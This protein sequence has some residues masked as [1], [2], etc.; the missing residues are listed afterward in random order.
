MGQ[1][2]RRDHAPVRGRLSTRVQREGRLSSAGRSLASRLGTHLGRGT[3]PVGLGHAGARW[4][5]APADRPRRRRRLRHHRPRPSRGVAPGRSRERPRRASARH[6]SEPGRVD[7][8]QVAARSW[9][10]RDEALA[11]C[12]SGRARPIAAADWLAFPPPLPGQPIFYQSS[13]R[14]TQRESPETGTPRIPRPETRGTFLAFDLYERY[15]A[16]FEP[17]RVGGAGIDELSIP[18]E[19]LP[20]LN[21][22]IVGEIRLVADY[23]P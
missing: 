14:T 2:G 6:R 1:V 12:R 22:N 8:R 7:G 5:T 13:T 23:R 9:N 15:A 11:P 16:G 18:A 20:L 21:S 4:A 10:A 3:N 17:H 19:E